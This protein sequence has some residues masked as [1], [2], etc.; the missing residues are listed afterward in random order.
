ML[1][2][3]VLI[4][5]ITTNF[6]KGGHTELISINVGCSKAYPLIYRD[7]SSESLVCH[8]FLTKNQQVT[9]FSYSVLEL[10]NRAK[11]LFLKML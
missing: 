11:I 6:R 7:N 1:K 5:K 2:K 4:K 8:E 10:K 3:I 9:Y